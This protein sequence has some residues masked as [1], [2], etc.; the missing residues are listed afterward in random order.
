MKNLNASVSWDPKDTANCWILHL[1]QL[2]LMTLCRTN[3]RNWRVLKYWTH[4]GSVEVK[5]KIWII[6]CIVTR[7]GLSLGWALARSDL[8]CGN[9]VMLELNFTPRNV[10]SLEYVSCWGSLL[11]AKTFTAKNICSWFPLICESQLSGICLYWK[12]KLN[13]FFV[14]FSEEADGEEQEKETKRFT[15]YF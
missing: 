10:A 7:N 13:G 15:I 6:A 5:K 12:S 8:I 9:H 2:Q 4:N 14:N 3:V 1:L 11:P